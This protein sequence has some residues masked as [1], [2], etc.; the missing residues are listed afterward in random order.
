MTRRVVI[1]GLLLLS[2]SLFLST[3]ALGTGDSA[4]T[5]ISWTVLPFARL[6]LE[7]ETGQ[8]VTTTFALPQP[9]EA[10]LERGYREIPRALTLIAASNV[11]WRLAVRAAEP[12]LGR[13][14]DGS[15]TKPLSDFQLR[16]GSEPY[17]PI[18]NADQVIAHGP[19]GR[20][21]VEVDYLILFDRERHRPGDY[22]VTLTYTITTD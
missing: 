13:S 5:T 16:V 1:S 19:S 8:A 20:K 4:R 2:L 6:S 18:S 9:S 10:D 12:D 14:Y 3:Q 22:H 7:G 21:K 15:Y 11:H 17:L